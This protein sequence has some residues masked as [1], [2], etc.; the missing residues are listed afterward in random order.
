MSE[1]TER[2]AE[3]SPTGLRCWNCGHVEFRVHYT[4]RRLDAVYRW[5][6]CL[7]CG[8]RFTTCERRLGV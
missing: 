6:E 7:N 2:P 8:K 5:R 1:H 4:R 3:A